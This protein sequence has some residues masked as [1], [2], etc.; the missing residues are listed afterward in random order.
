MATT[1]LLPRQPMLMQHKIYQNHRLSKG[2]TLVELLVIT[3]VVI[4]V[5]GGFVGAIIAMTGN[6]LSTRSANRLVYNIQ[7]ALDRIEA[8]VRQSNGF[9]TTNADTPQTGQGKGGGDVKFIASEKELII[10]STSQEIG[11][12]EEKIEI[13]KNNDTNI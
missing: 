4:L 11:N 8:D 9:L 10:S 1:N 6:V 7:D 2:F 5:I 12:I 13:E 3:P